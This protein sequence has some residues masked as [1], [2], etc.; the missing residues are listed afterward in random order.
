[1][2]KI[3]ILI[4]NY[5][6]GKTEL[7]L[8]LAYDA[9]AS[10]RVLAVDLDMINT[11]FRLYDHKDALSAAG[12]TMV[13]PALVDSGIEMLAI[14]PEIAMAFDQEWDTVI[15]DLGGDTGSAAI[16]QFYPKL[17]Q[18]KEQGAEIS[19]YNVVN[20]NRP[21]ADTPTKIQRLLEKMQGK[22]RWP[23][24]GF[25]LNANMAE[26]TTPED[27]EMGY[28]MLRQAEK[29]SGVPICYIAGTKELLSEFFKLHGYMDS[30]KPLELTPRMHRSW[31]T[32]AHDL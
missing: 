23:I 27:L 28:K 2:K 31:D 18:A 7:A 5:G 17:L 14:P 16:G 15:F 20:T 32:M 21:M 11:Y 9:A 12:I 10:G 4:G 29:D 26:E 30:I 19:V 24:T 1:M 3:V 22:V 6:S 25:I 13:A 8:Q